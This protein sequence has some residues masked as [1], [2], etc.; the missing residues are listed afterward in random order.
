LGRIRLSSAKEAS[1]MTA[2]R[3]RMLDDL[4]I[5]NCASTIECYIRSVASF[6]KH[7]NKSPDQLGPEEIRGY[8][9]LLNE[10][11]VKLST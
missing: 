1:A 10:R 11:K 5:R 9:F 7:F 2:L 3:Q 6:A 4:R 8:Q